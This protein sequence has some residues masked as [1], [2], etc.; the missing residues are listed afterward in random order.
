MQTIK[1]GKKPFSFGQHVVD[2]FF[3]DFYLILSK[4]Q[5]LLKKF[6]LTIYEFNQDITRVMFTD[7][8]KVNNLPPNQKLITWPKFNAPL[9]V[10]PGKAYHSFPCPEI[11]MPNCLT[12]Q[13]GGVIYYFLKDLRK[14]TH[15]FRS[16]IVFRVQSK[17]SANSA[18]RQSFHFQIKL[19]ICKYVLY[20]Y[21]FFIIEHSPKRKFRNINCLNILFQ[22]P[23]MGKV[24][25]TFC[26][27][28]NL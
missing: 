16:G 17:N 9:V 15:C 11:C 8:Q 14:W 27:R 25:N 20:V 4:S 7:C 24:R 19:K 3:R 23:K 22:A 1:F 28:R 18:A 2:F 6:F 21:S 26:N 13:Q 5:I 12:P 10:G